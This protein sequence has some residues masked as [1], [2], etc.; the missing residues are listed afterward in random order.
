MRITFTK[1]PTGAFKL[2]YSA[3]DTADIKDEKLCRAI[4]D[5]GYGVPEGT[6]DSLEAKPLEE[7]K[8]PELKAWAAV[9]NI[10]L[11][12]ATKKEDILRVLKSH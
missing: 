4:I 6:T 5:S 1:S 3:G 9:R 8:L 12:E 11:G 7:M 10:D 2:M